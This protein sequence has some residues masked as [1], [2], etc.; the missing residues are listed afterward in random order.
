MKAVTIL[1]F[2]LFLVLLGSMV[3]AGSLKEPDIENE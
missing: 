3:Y 1:M 2:I